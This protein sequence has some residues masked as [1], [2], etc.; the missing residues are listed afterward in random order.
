MEF[1]WTAHKN[2][3]GDVKL[4]ENDQERKDRRRTYIDYEKTKFNYDLVDSEISLYQRVKNRV[5]EVRS[6]SRVQR[7]SVVDYLNVIG[8][9]EAQSVEWGMEGI[10]TYFKAVYEYFCEEFGAE[11]IVSAKVL[12][13]EPTPKMHLHLVPINKENGKLQARIVMDRARVNR[14]HNEAP[15]YLTE[16][17]FEVERSRSK[18]RREV[19]K[20]NEEIEKLREEYKYILYG[21]DQKRDELNELEKASE[22]YRSKLEA[23]KTEVKNRGIEKGRL[24][25]EITRLK[26]EIEKL[27]E[28]ERTKHK[29]HIE[30]KGR[31][32]LEI[33]REDLKIE[34]L[35][36]DIEELIVEKRRVEL[37]LENLKEKIKSYELN[38]SG[39][40]LLERKIESIDYKENLFKN[41]I[42][43]NKADFETI[44]LK[45]MD[46]EKIKLE[47]EETKEELK[48]ALARIEIYEKNWFQE[49]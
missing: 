39:Q 6:V 27:E 10:E 14:I 32:E 15:K 47:L 33:F 40:Y 4:R 3:I 44:A 30:E 20:L 49:K 31:K 18:E 11:N 36:E 9:L 16:R 12:L 28:E 5:E 24:T 7:N 19:E 38:I 48:E 2:R 37:D 35:A 22:I 29:E 13:D 43:I 34:A 42:V 45:A 23:S 25:K 26:H 8:I 17:G 41:G 1:I 46:R 21:I